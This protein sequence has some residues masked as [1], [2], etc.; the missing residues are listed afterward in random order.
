MEYRAKDIAQLMNVSTATV[1]LV[2]NNKPGVSEKKRKEILEKIRE[3]G[4]EHMLKEGP[5]HKGSVG[6]VVYKRFGEIVDESPFFNYFMEGV[7]GKL[8]QAGYNLNF[9]V[10]NCSMTNEEQLRHIRTMG[11]D[12]LIIFGVEMKHDDLR[13]FKESGLPF[14]I[15]DNTFSESDVDSV[16]INNFQ[17]VGLAVKHLYEKGH[18]KIG[19]IRCRTRINSFEERQQAFCA[20]LQQLGLQ[21][22]EKYVVNVGYSESD[23]R[24][25][26]R[27]Y[28]SSHADDLPTAFFAE[29]DFLG[30]G[31]LRGIKDMGY[32]VPED[33]SII[34][35]DNRPITQFVN[36]KLSTVNVPKD[37][38]GPVAVD[39]LLERLEEGR[40]HSIKLQVGTDL[41]ERGS[42]ADLCETVNNSLKS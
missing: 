13:A 33:F 29:N 20:Y 41:I 12:G 40:T 42:A 37:I 28:L 5:E 30:C 9:N 38:F 26:I 8:N 7:N 2:I 4:C 35:F 18:R 25:G 16:A 6:F 34:G 23:A 24:D 22:E 3:L 15:L 19:Y 21:C 1:S 31:A 36:P 17:G 32:R 10:M 11:C 39:L 14:I 27:E